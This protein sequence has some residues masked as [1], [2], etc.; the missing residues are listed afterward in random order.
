MITTRRKEKKVAHFSTHPTESG[1]AEKKFNVTQMQ[2]LFVSIFENNKIKI[3]KKI[4][5]LAINVLYNL[6]CYSILKWISI[7]MNRY[8][9]NK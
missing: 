8:E 9:Y 4:F 3:A 6:I 2:Y 5:T 7:Y 1:L